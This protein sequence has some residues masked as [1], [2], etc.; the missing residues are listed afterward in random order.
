MAG[1]KQLGMNAS[2]FRTRKIQIQAFGIRRFEIRGDHLH[3]WID[4]FHFSDSIIPKLIKI[5]RSRIFSHIALQLF[6]RHVE[7]QRHKHLQLNRS[8]GEFPIFG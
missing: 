3:I 6:Q 4:R 8:A 1:T 5:V 7:S 2:S